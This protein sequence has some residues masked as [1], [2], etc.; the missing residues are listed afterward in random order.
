MGEHGERC[1]DDGTDKPCP[2]CRGEELD[3]EFLARIEEAAAQPG[4]T[5]TFDEAIAWLRAR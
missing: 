3:P 2:I 4:I 1:G 5:M